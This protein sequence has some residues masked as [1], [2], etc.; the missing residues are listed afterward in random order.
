MR[1][2]ITKIMNT[3]HPYRAIIPSVPVGVKRPLWSVMIP[4]YNCAAYLRETL[5][6][7]LAQDPGP[8][9]MQIMVVD[10]HSTQDDPAAVVAEIGKGRV[11]FYQQP[12]NVGITRN[13][14]TCLELAVGHLVHQL[15]GDDLVQDGFYKK[16]AQAFEQRSEV[17]AAFCRNIFIDEHSHPQGLSTLEQKHSGILP[18]DWLNVIAGVCCIQTPSIVVR[19]QVY[20]KL[21]GFD[22]RL[23]CGEDWEMWVRIAS[24]Y[25]MWYEVE[26]LAAYR[27]R[28]KS[29][30]RRNVINGE[31]IENLYKA[32]KIFASYLPKTVPDSVLSQAKLNCTYFALETAQTLFHQGDI[33]AAIAQVKLALKFH[34]SWRSMMSTSKTIICNGTPSLLRALSSNRKDYIKFPNYVPQQYSELNSSSN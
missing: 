19:R 16:M 4:T 32:I 18:S 12:K 9:V 11:E 24:N 15:H 1:S 14:Q 23:K 31:Y 21:G 30:T 34:N 26:P 17:G 20:E 8:D 33:Q 10:D 7:V 2:G 22:H 28:S 5:A 25:P 6:S 3:P 29:Q 27:L 13:F